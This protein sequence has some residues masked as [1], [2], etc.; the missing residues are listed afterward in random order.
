M[1][2]KH[3]VSRHLLRV[4]LATL[5]TIHGWA[6]WSNGAVTP[7]GDWLNQLG[8]LLGHTMAWG[9]TGFEILA[10]PLLALGWFVRPILAVMFVIYATG[11]VLVHWP[12]GWFVVGLGRNGMEYSALILV[13]IMVLWTQNNPPAP[14]SEKNKHKT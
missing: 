13:C 8:F 9:I 10:M 11:L 12:A 6:R 2:P 14:S 4:T 1:T 3:W 5:I 7:F